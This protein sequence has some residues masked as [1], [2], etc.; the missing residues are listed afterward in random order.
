MVIVERREYLRMLGIRRFWCV[1]RG[2]EFAR[3]GASVNCVV[4]EDATPRIAIVH[5]R[6]LLGNI[7]HLSLG[8]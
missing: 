2:V 4:K 5:R 1:L 3:S 8:K 6:C 7:Y